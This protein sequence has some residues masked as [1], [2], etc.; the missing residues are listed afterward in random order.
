MCYQ[1]SKTRRR[2]TLL[3]EEEHPENHQKEEETFLGDFYLATGDLKYYLEYQAMVNEVKEEVEK[4]KANFERSLAD[5]VS[6]RKFF[7][8]MRSKS[9]VAERVENV[10]TTE[11]TTANSDK[12]KCEVLNSFFTSVF[13]TPVPPSDN[14]EDP[15]GVAFEEV[16]IDASVVLTK[17]KKLD[18]NKAVGPDNISGKL[19]KPMGD[20][21]AHPISIIF[22]KSLQEG[23]VPKQWS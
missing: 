12:D 9:K 6:S 8:Y 23:C 22:N 16:F 1:K 18:V 14:P 21:L 3:D 7:A 19:L 13:S 17:I 5:T 2:Q 11:G 10:K 20:I 15:D 4:A